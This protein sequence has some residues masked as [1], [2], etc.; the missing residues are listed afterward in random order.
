MQE[1]V[2]W[3]GWLVHRWSP[4]WAEDTPSKFAARWSTKAPLPLPKPTLWSRFLWRFF[5]EY[6]FNF[7]SLPHVQS[8]RF[9]DKKPNSAGYQG[10]LRQMYR[11]ATLINALLGHCWGWRIFFPSRLYTPPPHGS[12]SAAEFCVPGENEP[13]LC[14][15]LQMFQKKGAIKRNVLGWKRCFKKMPNVRKANGIRLGIRV[16]NNMNLIFFP[17]EGQGAPN[18]HNLDGNQLTFWG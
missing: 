10:G 6:S 16:Q 2:F 12:S 14:F 18:R 8:S 17:E 3:I 1:M 13:K 4:S 5:L 11:A 9:I 15:P 7:F